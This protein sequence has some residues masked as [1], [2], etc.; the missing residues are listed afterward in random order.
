MKWSIEFIIGTLETIWA[1]IVIFFGY[2]W[3][4]QGAFQGN[5]EVNL[6]HVYVFLLCVSIC[7]RHPMLILWGIFSSVA[8]VENATD[9]QNLAKNSFSRAFWGGFISASSLLQFWILSFL[10]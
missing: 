1:A 8:N 10:L 5:E 2:N 4:L 9:I 6:L 7:L 3:I